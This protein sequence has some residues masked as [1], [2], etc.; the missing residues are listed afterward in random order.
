[1]VSETSLPAVMAYVAQVEPVVLA[2][3]SI[4]AVHDPDAPGAAGSV[5]QVRDSAQELVRLAKDNDIATVLVGHVTKD[6]STRRSEGVGTCCRHRA[7]VRG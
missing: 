2:I 4:Q 3:D 6:G 5:A 7:F 1:M